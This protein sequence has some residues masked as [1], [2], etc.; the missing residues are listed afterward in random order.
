MLASLRSVVMMNELLIFDACRSVAFTF[1]ATTGNP[2]GVK[3]ECALTAAGASSGNGS[4]EYKAC[5]SPV[6]YA[7]LADGAYNFSVRAQGEDS[8]DSRSFVKVQYPHLSALAQPP[9]LLLV[10]YSLVTEK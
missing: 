9:S 3:F 4:I 2:S 8:A 6:T 1:T 5:T 7:D 10:E